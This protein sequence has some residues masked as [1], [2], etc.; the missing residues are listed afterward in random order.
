M[1]KPPGFIGEDLPAGFNP[2]VLGASDLS[3]ID[4]SVTELAADRGPIIIAAVA[5]LYTCTLAVL[6]LRLVAKHLSKGRL[7][8][9]DSLAIAALVIISNRLMF[10]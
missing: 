6:I 7:W 4:Y 3:S 2:G 9:D 10:L 8:W 1:S 5:T